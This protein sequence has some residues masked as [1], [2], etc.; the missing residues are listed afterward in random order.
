MID[1]LH[2]ACQIRRAMFS[3]IRLQAKISAAIVWRHEVA[4]RA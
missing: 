4:R 2:N 3:V 1:S